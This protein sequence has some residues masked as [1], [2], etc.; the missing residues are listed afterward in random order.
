MG[1][2]VRRQ[3]LIPEELWEKARMI[4]RSSHSSVSAVVRRALQGYFER[5]S[6]ESPPIPSFELGAP[7]KLDREA[8]YGGRC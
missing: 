3:V 6:A 4:A 2:L 8:Y 1:P 5:E 7:D